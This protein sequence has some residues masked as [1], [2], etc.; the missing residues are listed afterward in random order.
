VFQAYNLI[1][2]VP[3]I[4]QVTLPL[5]YQGVPKNEQRARAIQALEKVGLAH[6]I[7]RKPNEMS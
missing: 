2:R 1:P 3:V 4:D 7:D 5:L 6:K